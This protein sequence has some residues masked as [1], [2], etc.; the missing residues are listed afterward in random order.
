MCKASKGMDREWEGKGREQAMRR[1]QKR[2]EELMYLH[3]KPRGEGAGEQMLRLRLRLLLHACV[4]QCS[5]QHFV[6]LV[7]QLGQT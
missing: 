4:F 7:V 5:E 3:M 6:R 2:A 1:E